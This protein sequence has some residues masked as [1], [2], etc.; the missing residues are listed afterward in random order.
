MERGTGKASNSLVQEKK[1][2]QAGKRVGL[3]TSKN[4]KESVIKCLCHSTKI[5]KSWRRLKQEI[6]HC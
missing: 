3:N 1:I 4:C 5:Q 2:Y 6:R